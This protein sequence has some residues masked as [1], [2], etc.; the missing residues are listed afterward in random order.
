MADDVV[1][2]NVR[3]TAWTVYRVRHLD[4]VP[5]DSGRWW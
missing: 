2:E 3:E 5:Q 1:L 4:V